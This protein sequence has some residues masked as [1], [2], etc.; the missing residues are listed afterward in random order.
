MDDDGRDVML[1]LLERLPWTH[2]RGRE[3]LGVLLLHA[4]DANPDRFVAEVCSLATLQRLMQ[5]S[6][7][8]QQRDLHDQ[9]QGGGTFIDS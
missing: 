7:G 8:L 3:A 2:G 5:H 9:Q 6:V 1:F 4:H